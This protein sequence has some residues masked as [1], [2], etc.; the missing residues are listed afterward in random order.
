MPYNPV[1]QTPSKSLADRL[2]TAE[3]DDALV[4]QIHWKN[5]RYDGCTVRTKEINKYTPQQTTPG[6]IGVSTIVQRGLTVGE[7]II[8]HT[9]TPFVIG[10]GEDQGIEHGAS[11]IGMPGGFQVGIYP[12]KIDWIGDTINPTG[13]NA[14]MKNETTAIYISNTVIGGE[15]DEQFATIKNHSYINIHQILLINHITEETQ[16]IDK[17]AENF[18]SFHTF[19]TND[20]P[21]QKSFSIK[22]IDESI[23]NNLKGSNEYKVKI[24]K[25]FLL[26]TFDY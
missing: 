10:Q 15:E 12:G 22:L 26:K 17:Q 9:S 2:F 20:L 18:N 7:M 24:N 4:D 16:L 11:P 14:N 3:F 1:F 13:L 5:P 23:A 6:G 8:G 25:G 19:V 21:T